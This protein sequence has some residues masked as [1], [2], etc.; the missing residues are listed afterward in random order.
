MTITKSFGFSLLMYAAQIPGYLSAAYLNERLGRQATIA[1]YMVLG[2]LSAVG[3]AFSDATWQIAV[4]GICLSFFMNGTFGGVYAYTPE[5]FP[6][7]LRATGVG[8]SSSFGRIGAVIAPILVGVI[9]PTLGFAGV[10]GV[11][12]CILLAGAAVVLIFGIPTRGLALEDIATS[13]N[14]PARPGAVPVPSR[15]DA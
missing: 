3:M 6:T 13:D 4:A 14:Q 9:Y 11:T 15:G 7:H 12:T 5:I 8:T 10:F 2:G 1:T